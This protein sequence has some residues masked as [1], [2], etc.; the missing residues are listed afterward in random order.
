MHWSKPEML[1]SY[2]CMYM[3]E[4]LV[5]YICNTQNVCMCTEMYGYVLLLQ[6]GNCVA[7]RNYR[8]F[9]LFL[10]TIAVTGVYMMACNIT[11]IVLGMCVMCAQENACS[12]ATKSIH[13]P[14]CNTCCKNHVTH[15]SHTLINSCALEYTLTKSYM[16]RSTLILH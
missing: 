3:P 10:T 12:G 16:E 15:P 11:V 5:S 8:Y 4:I 6:V 9:Y 7:R 14:M 2:V 13:M 1:A